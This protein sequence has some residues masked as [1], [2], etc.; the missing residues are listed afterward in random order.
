MI[1]L[2]IVGANQNEKLNISA[3]VIDTVYSDGFEKGD[4][5]IIALKDIQYVA[6]KLDDKMEEAFVYCPNKW[7]ELEVPF[8]EERVCYNP[9]SFLGTNQRIKVREITN[10]EF[11]SSRKISLN[12]YDRQD[13]KNFPH[14]T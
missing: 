12:P 8:G 11:C 7:F 3:N 4:K 13:S 1:N 6:M 9:E 14:D 10:E 2:K 5:I